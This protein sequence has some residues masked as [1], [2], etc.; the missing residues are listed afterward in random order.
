DL[1]TRHVGVDLH[2]HLVAGETSTGHDR[3]DRETLVGKRFDDRS[4][5]E[6]G[7][8]DQ[9][10]EDLFRPR[11]ERGANEQSAQIG[12]AERGSITV[13]PVEPENAARSRPEALSFSRQ[14]LLNTELLF[15]R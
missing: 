2:Q 14:Q 6:G 4:R 11:A 3:S 1:T 5:A 12:S 9:R 10:V 8:L 13:P 15:A 7:C